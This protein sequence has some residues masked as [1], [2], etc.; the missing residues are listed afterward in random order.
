MPTLTYKPDEFFIPDEKKE[1]EITQFLVT[2]DIVLGLF[3][4]SILG[5]QPQQTQ[6]LDVSYG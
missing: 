2:I 4:A 6:S 1:E 5:S 3:S